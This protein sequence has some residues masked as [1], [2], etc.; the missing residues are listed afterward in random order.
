ML[1]KKLPVFDKMDFEAGQ[2]ISDNNLQLCLFLVL[3]LRHEICFEFSS[4]GGAL[5][6]FTLL[7]VKRIGSPFL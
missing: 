1:E 4:G 3:M 6:I 7:Y 5:S 2:R